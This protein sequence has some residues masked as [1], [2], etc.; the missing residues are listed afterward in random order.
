MLQYPSVPYC[1]TVEA[2][3]EEVEPPKNETALMTKLLMRRGRRKLLSYTSETFK[4]NSL[5]G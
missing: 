2:V 4:M 5:S 3:K 1:F